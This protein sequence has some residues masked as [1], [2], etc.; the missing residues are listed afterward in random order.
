[1]SDKI[2]IFAG[3]TEGRQLA[4]LLRGAADVTVCVATE[5]GE[6]LLDGIDGITVH[7]GRM[8]EKEMSAFFAARRFDRI[9]DATHPYAAAATENI[10]AAARAAGLSP[11]RI[12]RGRADA[13]S[14]AVYVANAAAA[15]A[16]LAGREG[17][18]LLTTGAKELAAFSSLDMSRVFARVLPV[19]S[20]LDACAQAG[21]PSAHIF[22]A[23]G[24]FSEEMNRAELNMIGAKY[25]VTKDSGRAGGFA[26]KIAAARACGVLPVVIGRPPQTAGLTFD[27]AIENLSKTYALPQREIFLVG[28]GPGGEALR[29]AEA[30]AAIER[31]DALIGAPSVTGAI[32]TDK[33]R[34]DAYTP[35]KVRQV[36]DGAPSIRRAALVFRGDTGFYSGAANLL[37][38]F[39]NENVR[40][41]PGVSSLACFAAKLGK[42]YADATV[43][44]LH[45]REE[46]VVLPVS[47]HKKVFL[48]TGGEHTP[49]AVFE[50]LTAYGFGDLLCAVGERLSYPDE[51]ITKGRASELAARTYDKLSVVWIEN[52][53]ADARTRFGID[54]GEFVR[55]DTPLTKSEVRAISLSKLAL[56]CTA[57]VWDIGAG[58]GSVS[59]ECALAAERGRVFAIEK[60]PDAVRLI[61]ENK[62][63]FKT[64]NLTV[65]PG[66]APDA[67]SGLPAPTHAFIGGSGGRLCEILACLQSANPDVKIVLN[68]VTLESQS[69]LLAAAKQCGFAIAEA[70]AVNVA[71]ART[72]GAYHLWSAQNPVTVFVLRKETDA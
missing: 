4:A 37:D 50:K 21:I 6:V 63:K 3:T 16:Y 17:N 18:I 30:K 13:V 56:P 32:Q 26:E 27:E 33:P 62:L 66:E 59:V 55:G 64:D 15:C 31:C 41:I 29:T 58:T 45:G 8:D 61:E 65:I 53:Q 23:Q 9:I 47:K 49:T 67:F 70:A 71:R 54:D 19:T 48:L 69:Q 20:S 22:A 46:S 38:G 11:M 35:D 7:R 68:T 43:V 1:M 60:E 40:V 42:P 51:R 36:L 25:I 44:S 10:A 34:Y 28:I 57:T 72:A 5:Y 12:L 2:C 14:D 39:A 52:P 24:P